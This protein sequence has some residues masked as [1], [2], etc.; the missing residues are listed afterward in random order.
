MKNITLVEQYEIAKLEL[1]KL[2]EMVK[3]T[4]TKMEADSTESRPNSRRV[5]YLEDKLLIMLKNDYSFENPVNP[6]GEI[7]F[8]CSIGDKYNSKNND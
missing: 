8:A 2:Y 6:D 1:I 7:K 4:H 3:E 5:S